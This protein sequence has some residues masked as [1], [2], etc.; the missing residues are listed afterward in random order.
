MI[1]TFHFFLARLPQVMALATP[2]LFG[3]SYA[4]QST[5]TYYGYDAMGNVTAVTDPMGKVTRY[6]YDALNRRIQG[7][8]A[9]HGITQFGYNGQNLLISVSDPRSLVTSY[10]TDGLGNQTKL[11]SPDTGT[12]DRTFDASG[13]MISS[14]DAKG[15]TASYT[16]DVLN[17]VTQI[18]YADGQI[19]AM[20]YDQGNYGLGRLSQITDSSGS[21]TYSYDQHGR[22]VQDARVVEGVAV[23][24]TYSYDNAGQL[25]SLTYPSGRQLV[26]SRDALGRISQIVS[27]SNGVSSTVATNV[28]YAPTGKLLAYMNGAGRTVQYTTDLD[29]RTTS[30]SL[31]QQTR[32]LTYDD[33]SR[34]VMQSD[35]SQTIQFDYDDLNRLTGTTDDVSS[36][37]Y[38]YDPVG[39][40]TAMENGATVTQYSYGNQNNRLTQISDT[41]LRAIQSDANGSIT[42]NVINQFIYDARGRLVLAQTAS[43]AVHYRINTLGQRVS[44]ITP[45]TTTVF[46]YDLQGQLIGERSGN[47]ETDYMYLN[48]IPVAVGMSNSDQMY[49]IYT[50]QLNTPRRI[51]DSDGNTVWQWDGEPFGNTP[52]QVEV[53]R[54]GQFTF[55]LRFP[56]QYADSETG[57]NHNYFRDYDPS[58]GRYIEPDPIGLAGGS[59]STYTYALGNPVSFRD[60][61]GEIVPIFVATGVIG[62]TGGFV[63]NI[64]YQLYSNGMNFGQLNVGDALIAGAAGGVAGM[65]L[66]IT[67]TTF[68]GAVLTG[69]LTNE[70]GYLATQAYDGQ[71]ATVG[72]ALNSILWGAVGGAVA[73]PLTNPYWFA[74]D[75]LSAWLM[76]AE[77]MAAN[78]NG[79]A[80]G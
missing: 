56:G 12:T 15:Q 47:Q 31:N 68:L 28:T 3:S 63:G 42:S 45:I 22:V 48:G 53:T 4:A 41:E 16:Y 43:G 49:Y 33:G 37:T 5:T 38:S 72:G 36:F 46:N 58:T 35:P 70:V 71:T 11:I 64:G 13:N 32:V 57:L 2:I 77:M 39:N 25:A 76:D 69:G 23:K 74:K 78:W 6:T 7:V 60:P 19:S 24:A 34:L 21:T 50:D 40:R 30:Y 29:G 61:S 18:H 20:T 79:M 51:A 67:G 17:R 26:Y 8:D 55:N 1:A 73:G 10:Q 80:F 59:F 54:A 27:I 9:N 65:M 14:T 44:K 52:P 75:G 66:P 62:A